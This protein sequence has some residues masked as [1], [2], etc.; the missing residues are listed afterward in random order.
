MKLTFGSNTDVVYEVTVRVIL[1]H[2]NR[3]P[4]MILTRLARK[5]VVPANHAHSFCTFKMAVDASDMF[6][7]VILKTKYF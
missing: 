2:T 3:K 5:L 1:W 7:T 4:E 6:P